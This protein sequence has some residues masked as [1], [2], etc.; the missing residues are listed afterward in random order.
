MTEQWCYDAFDRI[1][2][3]LEKNQRHMTD[4]TAATAQVTATLATIA[5][6]ISVIQ[7][8]AAALAVAHQA[9]DTAGVAEL[10]AKLKAGTDALASTFTVA[11]VTPVVAPVAAP[12]AAP[13]A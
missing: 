13:A 10:V 6:A 5:N 9:D 8:D 4:L 2:H 7:S 12:A 11:P 3:L 1:I